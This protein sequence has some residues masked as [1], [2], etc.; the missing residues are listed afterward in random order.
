MSITVT[1]EEPTYRPDGDAM[2]FRDLL[3]WSVHRDAKARV[4]LDR[5]NE[6]TRAVDSGAFVGA[7][8]P[9][10]ITEMA[11]GVVRPGDPLVNALERYPLPPE[12]MQVTVPRSVTTAG[13]AAAAQTS[14]NTAV[15]ESDPSMVDIQRSVATISGQ[16]DVSRQVIDRGGLVAERYIAMDLMEAVDTNVDNQLINGTNA[17]GQMLGLRNVPDAASVVWSTTGNQGTFTT[18]IGRTAFEVADAR[19]RPP[20][21]VVMTPRRFY[22]LTGGEGS[23]GDL[24]NT[25]RPWNYFDLEPPFVATFANLDVVVDANIPSN[26]GAATNEDVA[27]VIRRSDMPLYISP[28]M[29]TVNESTTTIS[30]NWGVNITGHR[31]AVWF[32]DRYRGTSTAILSGSGMSDPGNW[33]T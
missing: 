31:Y 13:T 17:N 32:P 3:N 11:A 5:H 4:R 21:T 15:A 10:F 33:V 14:Q 24:P 9:Q 22:W 1:R 7:V 23:T 20:D 28:L 29:V 19:L 8:V 12:G 25:A 18:Y 30:N 26:L 6:E 16:I 2:F 27:L